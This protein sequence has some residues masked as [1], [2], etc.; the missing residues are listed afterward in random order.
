MQNI[1]PE[2]LFAAINAQQKEFLYAA[3]VTA[4]AGG[5]CNS[6]GLVLYGGAISW[7]GF[8]GVRVIYG[9]TRM[10]WL[11]RTAYAYMPMAQYMTDADLLYHYFLHLTPTALLLDS[12]SQVSELSGDT[13][14]SIKLN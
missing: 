10:K 2:A 8:G 9:E 1:T 5:H 14:C 12:S 6:F 13:L 11:R 7:Q 4:P 3:R